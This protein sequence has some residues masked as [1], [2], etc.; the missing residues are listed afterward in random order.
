MISLVFIEACRALGIAKSSLHRYLSSERVIPD[1]VIRRALQYLSRE[2][3]E[4]I[5]SDWD[6][7]RALGL[8][9]EDESVDY[10]L[11]F[12]IIALASRDEHLKNAILRFVVQE[13]R[14]DLD[15]FLT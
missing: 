5:V 3:F 8:V 1:D 7:L 15:L 10:S 2:E 11:A 4:S 6:K 9:R 12:R 13:F 14:D